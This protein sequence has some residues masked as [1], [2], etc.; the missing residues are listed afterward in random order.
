MKHR[1]EPFQNQ[2]KVVASDIHFIG[3]QDGA[4]T[5]QLSENPMIQHPNPSESARSARLL[6]NMC[7]SYLIILALWQASPVTAQ[8]ETPCT[9][10]KVT[11]NSVVPAV[12]NRLTLARVATIPNTNS[13]IH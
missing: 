11:Y 1:K 2:R 6:T 10:A 5:L 8:E 12:M 7:W 9:A 13:D 4:T 3:E